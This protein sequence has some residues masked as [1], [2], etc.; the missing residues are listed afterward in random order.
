MSVP[1]QEPITQHTGNG[2]TT[3]FAYQFLLTLAADLEVTV[4][5]VDRFINADYSLSGLDNPA[6]GTITFSVA[7]P[8]GAIILLVRAVALKRDTSYQYAGDFQ[9]KT[10]NADFDRLWMAKQDVYAL[11]QRSIKLPPSD[12]PVSV[13]LP[14]ASIRAH[15][16]LVFDAVGGVTVS[17]D[18][19]NDQLVNVTG[20]AAIATTKAGEALASAASAAAS[21]VE[22][23]ST[24]P[25]T[26]AT[27]PPNPRPNAQWI[28]LVTGRLFMWLGDVDGFQ[29]VEVFGSSLDGSPLATQLRND[30]AAVAGASIVG[31]G[32][33][34]VASVAA[35]RALLKISVGQ[36]AFVTGY[37]A[38]GDGGGGSYWRDA[39]DTTSL[40]NGGTLIVAA[41]GGRW[42]LTFTHG[43]S[44]R[45]FGA[46]GD[47]ATLDTVAVQAALNASARVYVPQ[48]VYVC[49]LLT[50]GIA[51]EIVG[52]TGLTSILRN[53]AGA[54]ALLTTSKDLLTF[55]NIGLQGNGGKTDTGLVIA[56]NVVY[57]VRC[58]FD[59]FN[60]GVS[61]NNI[62]SEYRILDSTIAGCNFGVYN[63]G[64]G[65]NAKVKNCRIVTCKTAVYLNDTAL[66]NTEG[67]MVEDCLIYDCGSFAENKAVI[68]VAGHCWYTRLVNNMID[69]CNFICFRASGSQRLDFL[70]GYWANN[71]GPANY[72]TIILSGDCSFSK[73]TDVRV[74]FSPYY[75][76]QLVG[77]ATFSTDIQIS[78]CA[79]N[80]N[81][82][83][84]GGGDI[85]VESCLRTRIT[86]TALNTS[87]SYSLALAGTSRLADV[88]AS[89]SNFASA[90]YIGTAGCKLSGRGN[91]GFVTESGGIGVVA[92]GATSTTFAHGLTLLTG[93][94]ATVFVQNAQDNK[95]LSVAVVGAS[96]TVTASSSVAATSFFWNARTV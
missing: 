52:D 56:H 2:V 41:D 69:G 35:L 20:Q 64:K 96:A 26:S 86:A 3:S 95:T 10:V 79:F 51:T 54:G 92:N 61:Q 14:H 16:A 4:S 5:G 83:L 60:K 55:E 47:G 67:F 27:P 57:S 76:L 88:T 59:G 28:D 84:G 18:D 94:Q 6:G 46:I 72:S 25:V 29:W 50:T 15:K 24:V 74:E 85:L 68:E 73:F 40:D 77:A 93:Q 53:I 8:D 34:V 39:S 17:D 90:P 81:N 66:S 22:A 82:S 75:G 58:Y 37:Y 65:I 36:H 48:G 43:V 62:A 19:F 87:G 70:G 42:K 21:E 32:A 78:G 38:S 63:T 30:L 13:V 31:G 91:T 9:A 7:P 89:N 23:L 71:N 45:Q 49:G 44:V 1:A 33:R 80:N 11:T 12:G